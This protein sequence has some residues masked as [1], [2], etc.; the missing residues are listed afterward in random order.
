MFSK[1]YIQKTSIMLT[2]STQFYFYDKEKAFFTWKKFC[3]KMR[4]FFEKVEWKRLNLIKWQTFN[5]VDTIAINS[6]LSMSECLRKMIVEINIIQRNLNA[7]YHEF[8]HL[9]KNIIRTCRKHSTFATKLI[10]L[11]TNAISFIN[12]LYNSI[13]N[14]EIVHKFI[15]TFVYLQTQIEKNDEVFYTNRQYKR[16]K[17]W[18]DRFKNE[19]QFRIAF[20]A[21]RRI[22]K[23]FVC[24]KKNC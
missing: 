13:I 9:R 2:K 11:T 6:I 17:S 10:N 16:N 3:T 18:R 20:Q 8:I 23:C 5:I 7:I 14:Y 4:K 15:F 24:K 1:I 21:S 12:N 22:K 19:R